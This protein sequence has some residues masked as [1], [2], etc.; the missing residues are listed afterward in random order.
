[1]GINDDLVLKLT[2]YEISDI[3]VYKAPH[4]NYE[5]LSEKVGAMEG[6]RK[7][8]LY[9]MESLTVEG[10]LLSCYVSDDFGKLELVEVYEGDF[11]EY[12]NEIV[13]TG[14]LARSWGKKIGDTITVSANGVSSEYVICGLTQ[15]MNNFGRI[16]FIHETGLL[17]VEPYYEK[18]S[19]QVYLEPG[20][21]I[22]TVIAAME[23]KFRVLS[24]SVN[25]AV[26][27]VWRGGDQDR[28][29]CETGQGGGAGCGQAKGG[30]ETYRPHFH[31]RCGQRPVCPDGRR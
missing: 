14:L 8:S 9:E 31:V 11:P 15:T 21:D 2:G 3:M 20:L 22:D 13:I 7:V 5:E 25:D 19:I 4:E 1:M 26:R 16:C 12:D 23:Q 27:R 6:V 30:G 24:P 17:R 28:Y 10:E 18:S 29:K